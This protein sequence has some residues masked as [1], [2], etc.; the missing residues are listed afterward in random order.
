MSPKRVYILGAGFSRPA[1]LPLQS[2]ILGKIRDFHIMDISDQNV[3]D[4]WLEAYARV[5][6]LLT[7]FPTGATEPTLEDLFTLLDQTIAVRD[8]FAGL[9]WIDLVAARDALSRTTLVVLHRACEAMSPEKRTFYRGVAAEF[10]AERINA[11]Q[12]AD[13]CS[14]VSLN[15]DYLL[16]DS[17]Y[18]C[19]R[20]M[21]LLGRADVDFC[22]YTTPLDP[23]S[24]H[25]PS[26]TQKA[27]GLFNFKVLKLHG[28]ANFLRCPSCNR[29]FTA[30]GSAADAWTAYVLPQY[31]PHCPKF[32]GFITE[33]G[34]G[35]E[36]APLLEPHFVTPTYTKVFDS[37]HIRT[38]WH[39]AH[40]ELNEADEIVFIGYSFPDADYHV[41]T[42]LRRSVRRGTPVRVV[43]AERDRNADDADDRLIASLPPARYRRF[44]G[45]DV[46]FDFG[47]VASAFPEAANAGRTNELLASTRARA[48]DA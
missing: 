9:G 24:A 41:R 28:S 14:V 39:N 46:Q 8:S 48:V 4:A 25:V 16:E 29:L 12:K 36:N 37:A 11:G 44:F 43:L 23:A 32:V 27:R 22:C 26:I 15:W 21:E 1:Q 30:I 42:L 35:E 6:D 34:I 13:P 7:R 31:C 19:L 10:L 38:I 33:E 17:L 18:D 3:T 45:E 20:Q 5:V 40:I 2:E 47:G